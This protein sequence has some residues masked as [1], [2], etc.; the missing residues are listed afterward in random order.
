MAFDHTFL[1]DALGDDR[2]STGEDTREAHA[3]DRGTPPE[4]GTRPDAV[5]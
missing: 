5:V 4:D 3:T 2:V 1:V